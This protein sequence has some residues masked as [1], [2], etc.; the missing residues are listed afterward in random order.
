LISA[1]ELLKDKGLKAFTKKVVKKL[2][3]RA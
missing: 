2:I 1:T 3:G